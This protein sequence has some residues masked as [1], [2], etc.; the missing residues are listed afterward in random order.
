MQLF[1]L[2][3]VERV[4]VLLWVN[5]SVVE[6]FVAGEFLALLF[7]LVSEIGSLPDPIPNPTDICLVE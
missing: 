4:A 1:E 3:G 5:V 6:Y 7:P 2:S